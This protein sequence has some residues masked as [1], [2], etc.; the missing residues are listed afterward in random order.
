MS[1]LSSLGSNLTAAVFGA[2]GGIGATLAQGLAEDPS[3]ARVL[4][5]ARDTKGVPEHE[6]IE[7]GAFDLKNEETI[8]AAASRADRLDVV[9]VASG[10]LHTPDFGPEKTWRHLDPSAM[11]ETLAINTVGPAIIAKHFLPKLPKASPSVFAAI[12]ARVGS[13]SDNRLGGWYSYRASKSALNMVL[14]CA[15]I[16][17]ARTKPKA[18]CIGLHPGTVDSGLSK[19]FQGHVPDGKLFTAEQSADYLLKVIGGRTSG[20]SGKVFDWAGEEVPA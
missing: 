3:V 7:P 14:K 1:D 4:A 15:A 16:E 10:I 5:F 17:L 6:K 13:I 19:P 9:I 18:I 8:A 11:A 12:S 2:S 20:D